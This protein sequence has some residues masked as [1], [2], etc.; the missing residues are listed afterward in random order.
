M[1]HVLICILAEFYRI[2]DAAHERCSKLRRQEEDREM[3]EAIR[4][5]K[6]LSLSNWTLDKMNGFWG[7][8]RENGTEKGTRHCF[9][10]RLRG[11]GLD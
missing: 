3:M 10:P 11:W 4:Q 1:R 8:K 9:A 5:D 2:K 6:E 7:R